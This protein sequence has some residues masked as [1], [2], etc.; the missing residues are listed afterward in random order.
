[1]DNSFLKLSKILT[2]FNNLDAKIAEV[3]YQEL[4]SLNGSSLDLLLAAFDAKVRDQ[5]GDPEAL[6]RTNLWSDPT[7]KSVC[8]SIILA[9]YN[10]SIAVGG[11]TVWVAPP[12]L[13]FDALLWKAVEAHPPAI[14]GGYFGYW[15]YAPEN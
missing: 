1:M 8:Q 6:V 14:S 10:A 12:E 9:W 7:Y 15:R 13:Y 3:Y 11:N 5:P 2:G 4:H